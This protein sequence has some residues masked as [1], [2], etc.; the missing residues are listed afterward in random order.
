MTAPFN[1]DQPRYGSNEAAGAIGCKTQWLTD[2]I[3]G[4]PVKYPLSAA[5][6]VQLPQRRR[7][8]FTFRSVLHL[9]I[10][11]ELEPTMRVVDA[12]D[13]S[14]LVVENDRD[15]PAN[16]APRSGDRYLIILP[17]PLNRGEGR[18]Y[19]STFVP[20]AFLGDHLATS[21]ARSIA[22]RIVLNVTPVFDRVV[23]ELGL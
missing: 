1:W 17:N 8:L 19:L 4:R 7:F 11:H 3:S 15:F 5:E 21:G 20:G 14:R 23:R 12:R 18:R 13:C 6:V 16:L 22:P 2:L 10:I 9:A